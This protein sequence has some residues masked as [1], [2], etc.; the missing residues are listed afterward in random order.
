MLA[1]KIIRYNKGILANISTNLR[2]TA[3]IREIIDENTNSKA[4]LTASNSPKPN[5]ILDAVATC[6]GSSEAKIIR[7]EI[8][9]SGAIIHNLRDRE[10]IC[11]RIA[12][13]PHKT[14]RN[15][16]STL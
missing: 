8:I 12:V 11:G 14:P 4:P 5:E 16:V 9:M 13:T 2:P 1:I 6:I 10:N 7:I 3:L 15:I